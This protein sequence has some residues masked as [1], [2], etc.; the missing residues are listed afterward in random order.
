MTSTLSNLSS[1]H[2]ENKQT[3]SKQTPSKH[4]QRIEETPSPFSTSTNKKKLNHQNSSS[5]KKRPFET[6]FTL[7][8][9]VNSVKIPKHSSNNIQHKHTMVNI[10]HLK[11]Q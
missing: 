2:T 8:K 6:P 9:K 1:L 5:S 3:I 7:V 4:N 10:Y 11:F